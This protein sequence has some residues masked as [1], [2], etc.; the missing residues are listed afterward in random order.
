MQVGPHPSLSLSSSG[1][2]S[3]GQI[4]RVGCEVEA[5]ER[6]TPAGQ[7]RHHKKGEGVVNED[8]NCIN[9]AFPRKGMS[10]LH[11]FQEPPSQVFSDSL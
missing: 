3:A 10:C 7:T 2:Q 4:T 5:E 11:K 6:E 1:K 8:K 9:C